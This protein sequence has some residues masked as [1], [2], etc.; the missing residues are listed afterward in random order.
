MAKVNVLTTGNFNMMSADIGDLYEADSYV[1]TSTTFKA[2]WQ[3]GN[4][5]DL[6]TGTGFSFN[7][8]GEPISGTVTG[9]KYY[10][11]GNQV[12]VTNASIPATT[13]ASYA[14]ADNTVGAFQ[15]VLS[16]NDSLTGNT[17]RDKLYGYNGN[18]T[19]NGGANTDTMVGG[20][21]NDV[22]IVDIATDVVTELSGQGTDLIKSSVSYDLTDTD[23]TGSNGGNVERLTLTGTADTEGWGN[24]LNNV[25]TGNGGD[26]LLY[27]GNGNDKLIGKAG[28][29][30][31]VGV[32]GNDTLNGG[33][34]VDF[35]YGGAGKDVLTGGS[36]MDFFFFNTALNSSSN[37]DT[38]TDFT[39]GGVDLMVLDDD[40]FTALGPVS[41]ATPLA[42]AK[43]HKA[44]GATT[45]HDAD[46]R[47]I[48]N[49]TTGA[50]Y[51]DADGNGSSHSAVKFAV[52]GT[53]T[54]PT[55]SATDFAIIA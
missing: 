41:Q 5:Y 40:I 29:D 47:I 22:Y 15:Y 30:D 38:I 2:I 18:D 27:G 51:Y 32:N 55:L 48:Y 7:A 49:T 34:G 46:D 10:N 39:T 37:V 42:S 3:G 9:Y 21:G 12:Q 25:L 53:N 35:L 17:G 23:G 24:N 54:H 44:A 16:G 1:R 20:L 4:E 50:L 26:N 6:F 52:M 8:Q 28:D 33:N 31:L 45:A 14:Q 11:F 13:L 43:F 19:I 36:E